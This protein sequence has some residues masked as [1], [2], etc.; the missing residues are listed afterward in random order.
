MKTEP[1]IPWTTQINIKPTCL[2]RLR[3]VAREERMSLATI[4]GLAIET[5]ITA[6]STV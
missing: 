4:I 2:D 5:Y 6:G 3:S 1:R